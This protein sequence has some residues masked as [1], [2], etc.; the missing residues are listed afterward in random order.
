MKVLVNGIIDD[1]IVDGPGFRYV[2]FTQGCPHFCEGCHNPD[3]HD[4][5]KGYEISF[6]EILDTIKNNPLN[7]GVTFSGGEPMAQ[8]KILSNLAKEIKDLGKSIMIYSGYTFEQ[9]IKND[10]MKNLLSYCDILVDGRFEISQ[11]N[12]MLKFRGSSN[13][14]IIDVQKTLENNEI[15]LSYLH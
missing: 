7:D 1:S 4:F 6:D 14:R 11:K 9:I 3:T 2:I 5:K 13:Q 12:L 10:D 8:A 15:I